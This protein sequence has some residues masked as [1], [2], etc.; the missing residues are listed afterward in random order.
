M[1]A[2]R[3]GL[4]ET[5]L[6][7]QAMGG[8]LQLRVAS[9]AEAAWRAE[10]DLRRVTGRID[11]WAR[12]LTRFSPASDL[13]R[14]NAEPGASSVPLRPTIAVVLAHARRMQA[15]TDDSIDV[16]ML[17]ERLAVQDPGSCDRPATGRWRL[18]GRG[19][20]RR[21]MR[22]GRTRFDLDGVAKGWIADRALRLLDGYPS[23]LVDADGDIA[24][25]SDRKAGWRIA[26]SHP[27]DAGTDLAYLGLPRGWRTDRFGIATSGTSVHRWD[28]PAGPV[29]HL[30]DPRT[31]RPA[32]T[33]VAQATVVAESAAVAECLAKSA[34][35]HGSRRGL[36]LVERAGAWAVVLLLEDGDVVATPRTS[37]WLA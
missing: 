3:H 15:M 2:D 8:T 4:L 25:R 11:A 33:D 28:G 32:V 20:R 10:R 34:V 21:L 17:D 12:R 29:H 31:R 7:A 24:V 23:A 16:T 6:M 27:F 19:S 9:T 18:A 1:V 5:E 36:E 13:C 22:H 37:R 26:V 35:I 30:I 14:L